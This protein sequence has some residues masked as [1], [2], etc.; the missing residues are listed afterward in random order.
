MKKMYIS[1]LAL[2]LSATCNAQYVADFESLSLA[3]ESYYNG[4]PG[5]TGFLDGEVLF[6]NNYDTTWGS[7]DGFAVSN[8]TDNATA[9]WGNQYSAY[10]GSGAGGSS[11]YA[12]AYLDPMISGYVQNIVIDSFRITNATYAALSMRDGDAFA[13]QFGS[14]LDANGQPDGTNGEDYFKVWIICEDVFGNTFDSLD[15]YLAD[16]RFADSTQDYIVDDWQTIDLTV[17]PILPHRITFRFESSDVGQFGINTPL[18]FAIDDVYY[19]PLENLDE[20]S[21]PLLTVYPNPVQDQLT[22]KGDAG[23]ITV[24]DMNGRVLW[25]QMHYGTSLIDCSEWPRGSYFAILRNDNG[26]ATQ[27]IIK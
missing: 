7:W 1:V 24:T 20:L 26:T 6:N 16:Y 22:I 25:T 21:Q 5:L 18:Y 2:V 17:L 23:E 27:K 10:P 3:S 13:K 19:W 11:N 9:G 14:P 8:V 15:F 12:V 4:T